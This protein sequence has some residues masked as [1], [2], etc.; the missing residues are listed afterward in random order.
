MR[1]DTRGS[2]FTIEHLQLLRLFRARHFSAPLASPPIS[3][4]YFITE[5]IASSF[6]C[7]YTTYA[8]ARRRHIE[9]RMPDASIYVYHMHA[10]F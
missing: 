10:G 5:V 3:F 9:E 6:S 1:T 8:P 7:Y 4:R 2:L